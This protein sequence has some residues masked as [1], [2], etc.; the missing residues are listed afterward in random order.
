LNRRCVSDAPS[1]RIPTKSDPSRCCSTIGNSR[2]RPAHVSDLVLQTESA[3]RSTNAIAETGK[4]VRNGSPFG[5]C[6]A[7][8]K[9]TGDRYRFPIFSGRDGNRTDLRRDDCL[10]SWK[11][12]RPRSSV[13]TSRPCGFVPC[14]SLRRGFVGSRTLPKLERE[15]PHR[16]IGGELDGQVSVTENL[17]DTTVSSRNRE[18]PTRSET[19]KCVLCATPFSVTHTARKRGRRLD[20]IYCKSP[21]RKKIPQRVRFELIMI[22]YTHTHIIYISI[23][24]LRWINTLLIRREFVGAKNV[25]IL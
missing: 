5:V 2:E 13:A 6:I 25:Y 14:D 22:Y 11:V 20:E 15:I 1:K 8:G 3:G 21:S 17:I 19:K 16:V 12:S 23:T 7:A 10:A 18:F 9:W 4:V 24:T